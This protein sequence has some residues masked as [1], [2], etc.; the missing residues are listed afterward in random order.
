MLKPVAVSNHSIAVEGNREE[1][2][3]DERTV[4]QAAPDDRER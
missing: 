1:C 2:L 3:N 4:N